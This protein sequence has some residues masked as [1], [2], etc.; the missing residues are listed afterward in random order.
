[1][2]E[3]RRTDE[4]QGKGEGKSGETISS[5]EAREALAANEAHAVDIRGDEEWRSG[6]IP[7]A[8]HIPE[9]DLEGRSDDFPT[10]GQIII[11]DEDGEKAAQAAATLRDAGHDAVALDGGMDAWRSDDHPMQPSTDPD[12]DSPI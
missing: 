2:S 12:E 1:M 11:A 5:E 10:E 7:G 4:E 6:H 3:E 8:H 9:G